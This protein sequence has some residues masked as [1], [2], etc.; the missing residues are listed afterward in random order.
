M[1]NKLFINCFVFSNRFHSSSR[2]IIASLILQRNPITIAPLSDFE[3]EYKQ[4]QENIKMEQ[5][6]GTFNIKNS[7]NEV[8][9]TSSTD[10]KNSLLQ[11][12]LEAS[13]RDAEREYEAFKTDQQSL[14]RALERILYLTVRDTESNQWR[15]PYQLYQSTLDNGLHETGKRTL[16]GLISKTSEIYYVGKGPI[17]SHRWPDS[18]EFTFRAQILSGGIDKETFS[19]LQPT[20][21]DFAWLTRE[22]LKERLIPTFFTSIQ[23]CLSF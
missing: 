3:R 10:A 23:D 22:E 20:Y 17:A 11:S 1:I 13:I 19:N 8:R 6:R 15:L 7:L 2:K 9:Q 16:V 12:E 4:Y 21:S 14:N 5:T 18:S